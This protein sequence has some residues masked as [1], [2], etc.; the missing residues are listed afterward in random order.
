MH[1]DTAESSG[2]KEGDWVWIESPSTPYKIKQRVKV[3]D[4]LDRRVIYPDFGWWFPEKSAAEGLHGAWESNVNILSDDEPENCCPM[5]GSW[6]I[7][8]NLLKITPVQRC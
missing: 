7:N 5:I 4:G 6:Y 1:P 2:L 8:A 3:F